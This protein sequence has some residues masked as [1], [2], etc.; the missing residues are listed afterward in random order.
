[1]SAQC[2]NCNHGT[3]GCI[4]DPDEW[5]L[6]NEV[7]SNALSNLESYRESSPFRQQELIDDLRRIMGKLP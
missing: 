5:N 4:L 1:M 6:L 2:P 3:S 7:L